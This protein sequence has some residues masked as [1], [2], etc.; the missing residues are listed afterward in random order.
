MPPA[1]K[2]IISSREHGAKL[3]NL[4]WRNAHRVK[5]LSQG[6]LDQAFFSE[7]VDA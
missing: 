1:S 2:D 4:L 6:P 3:L 7:L 5:H